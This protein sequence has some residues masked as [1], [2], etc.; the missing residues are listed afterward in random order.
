MSLGLINDESM[1]AHVY[2]DVLNVISDE[3]YMMVTI[4]YMTKHSHLRMRM[5]TD[6]IR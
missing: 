3:T 1:S 2:K 6:Y 5:R 4:M